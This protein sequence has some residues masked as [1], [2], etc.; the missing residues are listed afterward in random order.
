MRN[1][2]YD[3][4]SGFIDIRTIDTLDAEISA[5]PAKAYTL[6]NI[7]IASLA[8]GKSIITNAL[9][10][11]DQMH[12]INAMRQLGVAIE[13]RD[14]NLIIEGVDGKLRQPEKEVF[15]GNSG[16]SVRLLATIAAL[17]EKGDVIITGDKRMQSGRP[18][19]DLLKAL[20]PLG[21]EAGSIRG[22]GCPPLRIVS[23]TFKGG[24]TELAG[25]KSSQY[26]SSIMIAAPYA[27]QDVV[28]NTNGTLSSKPYI[29]MTIDCM[30][31]FGAEVDNQD[32]KIFRIRAG[33]GYKGREIAVEGDYSS[34]S[35]F[36][37]AAAITGGRIKVTNLRIDSAQGDKKFVDILEMMGCEVNKGDGW[38]EIIG[39]QMNGITIDMNDYPDI[40]V[41]LAVVA[42][43]AKGRS[44][45]TNIG[46]L[47]Y[48]EC[49]R[50]KAPATELKKMGIN[51]I[52]TEDSLI[53]E[54]GAPHGAE[55]ET[56]NDH[57]IAMSFSIAGLKVS[58]MKIRNPGCVKKSFPD[59]YDKL[60]EVY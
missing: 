4:D 22:N 18:I 26:F 47:K 48:K 29:D 55:I 12:A 6:R 34:A 25:D 33:N 11:D 1:K 40:V 59:F 43:F 42:A 10:A 35:F 20:K 52:D 15:L 44:E 24:A 8:K 30:K 39:R 41:P 5:P 54:G 13:I 60:E 46:H 9:L 2:M 53:V 7:F 27:R 37:T 31:Q 17:A 58:G 49:D 38:I 3:I 57:R 32:Y 45:F 21:I 50:I 28:I 51:A 19:S 23:G 56:Y 14:N 36:F 16:V